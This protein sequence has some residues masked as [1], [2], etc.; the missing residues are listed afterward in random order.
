MSLT[1]LLDDFRKYKTTN[2]DFHSGNVYEHSVWSAMYTNWMMETNHPNTKDVEKSWKKILVFAALLHD[3]GK[4]GDENLV[5]FDKPNHPEIGGYYFDRGYYI[6]VEGKHLDLRRILEEA[7][8]SNAYKIISFI[9]KSHWLIGGVM[10][11]PNI[12]PW[13]LYAEFNKFCIKNG[14]AYENIQCL[15]EI[16]YIVWTADLMAT[17][18]FPHSLNNFPLSLE[19]PPAIHPGKNCYTYL[20]VDKATFREKMI[21]FYTSP[22]PSVPSVSSQP[23]HIGSGEFILDGRVYSLSNHANPFIWNPIPKLLRNRSAL[24]E[25][26]YLRQACVKRMTDPLKIPLFQSFPTV[27]SGKSREEIATLYA[28]VSVEFSEWRYSFPIDVQNRWESSE[29]KMVDKKTKLYFGRGYKSCEPPN[30]SNSR[31][32]W[33][34]LDKKFAYT[35]AIGRDDDVKF[36]T[37]GYCWNVLT[38]HPIRPLRLL[39]LSLRS[40]RDKVRNDMKEM[41][42]ENWFISLG[43]I[44]HTETPM[45]SDAIDYMFPLDIDPSSPDRVSQTEIDIEVVK[46]LAEVYPD[47]D[48]WYIESKAM[49]LEIVIFKPFDS[50]EMLRHESFDSDRLK[51]VLDRCEMREP[52]VVAP[53]VKRASN[54][55]VAPKAVQGPR[56][57]CEK[58]ISELFADRKLVCLHYPDK[59]VMCYLLEE[60]LNRS[61]VSEEVYQKVL[62][63]L[64]KGEVNVNIIGDTT[65]T[66]RV[67]P[68]APVAPSA[69]VSFFDRLS[70]K[71]LSASNGMLTADKIRKMWEKTVENSSHTTRRITDKNADFF[72]LQVVKATGCRITVKSVRKMWADSIT[73]MDLMAQNIEVLSGGYI[74]ADEAL[75]VWETVCSYKNTSSSCREQYAREIA[76]ESSGLMEILDVKRL[77]GESEKELKEWTEKVYKMEFTDPICDEKANTPD[78]TSYKSL[79]DFLDNHVVKPQTAFFLVVGHANRNSELAKIR[80]Y[81]NFIRNCKAPHV[82]TVLLDKKYSHTLTETFYPVVNEL[83]EISELL[84]ATR[85][86]DMGPITPTNPSDP[87]VQKLR[88]YSDKVRGLGGLFFFVNYAT[89]RAPA[90]RIETMNLFDWLHNFP[91]IKIEWTFNSDY[92]SFVDTVIRFKYTDSVNYPEVVSDGRKLSLVCNKCDHTYVHKGNKPPAEDPK[93]WMNPEPKVPDIIMNL[94]SWRYNGTNSEPV[95]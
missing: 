28:I 69:P 9:V 67:R 5:F 58:K 79:S 77:W 80:T 13:Y 81:P 82:V 35:Y 2:S 64:E 92:L 57:K 59:K 46:N 33:A 51:P 6:T 62:Q 37:R 20:G 71:L 41:P 44:D 47:I 50:L 43:V 29:L 36:P 78:T 70:T 42:L 66:T 7:G 18:R 87:I 83:Y 16:V 48:G 68:S 73:Y 27:I 89:F 45:Y 11:K 74:T 25:Y 61:I 24:S 55:L 91:A 15:F 22:F 52:K 54:A 23:S 19:N 3:I 53:A 60:L 76:G 72:A 39:N 88:R 8:L 14:Y 95:E 1:E 84:P 17:Q 30:I 75:Q 12:D 65:T 34:F 31:G 93:D 21:G 56:E 86:N 49:P 94:Q 63:E 32:M 85:K 10:N 38:Y 4:C 40:V 90:A 26:Q